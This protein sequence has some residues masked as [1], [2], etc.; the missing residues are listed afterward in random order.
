M[1]CNESKP[2]IL[3]QI[4]IMTAKIGGNSQKKVWCFAACNNVQQNNI[5]STRNVLS[6]TLGHTHCSGNDAERGI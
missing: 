5:K 1:A 2:Q 3:L 4:V 6:Q